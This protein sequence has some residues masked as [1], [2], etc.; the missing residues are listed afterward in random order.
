[1][2]RALELGGRHV[3]VGQRP[4]EG[5]VVLADPD[6]NEFCVIEAGNTFLAGTGF[7]G[8][9][10]CDGTREVGLFWS[11]AL[12]WPLVTAEAA[13]PAHGRPRRACAG[14]GP[15][16]DSQPWLLTTR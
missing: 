13:A 9:L 8:A 10:A 2:A 6:G 7:I 12:R 3:D 16:P 11:E 1:V 4:E 5:H 14:P 15:G